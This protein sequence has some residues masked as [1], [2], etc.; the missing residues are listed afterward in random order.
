MPTSGSAPSAIFAPPAEQF[1]KDRSPRRISHFCF[2]AR[3]LKEA[4]AAKAGA[5]KKATKES[6]FENSLGMKFVPV[7]GTDVL[8]SIWDTRVKDFRAYA[9]ATGYR[10]EGGICAWDGTKWA[11]DTNSSWER[12]EFLQTDFHPV[13]G[14]SWDEAKAFCQWLTAKERGEGKIGK[15]QEYRLPTDA[16]WSIAVG[17]PPE[18]GSTP[19]EKDARV[20]DV[21][22]WG[23]QWPPP[24][25]AGNYGSSLG[26]DS[27]AET[28]PVGSFRP[29][30]FGL[31]DMGGNVW[32]WC[33][34]RYSDGGA[35]RVVRGASWSNLV[36]EYL[37]SSCRDFGAPDFRFTNRGFRCVLGSLR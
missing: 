12:P 27:F 30:Q 22:P 20:R 28:S 15:D 5:W 35:S 19:K 36:P 4:E 9:E 26:V 3:I 11:L 32:Q 34:D 8:F 24:K 17:L 6:P 10:Q 18:S 7:P 23:T 16:Q 31:Y 33:E 13:V 2:C 29:N 25:G 37:L 1:F 14:V 21:Y